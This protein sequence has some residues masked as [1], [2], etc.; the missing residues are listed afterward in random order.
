MTNIAARELFTPLEHHLLIRSLFENDLEAKLITDN[1]AHPRAGL[2]AYNNR[3]IFGGDPALESFNKSLYRYFH[4][5]VIPARNGAAFLTMFTPDSWLGTLQEIFKEHETFSAARLSFE[6]TPIRA[7]INFPEG[8]S[9]QEVTTELLA[10]NTNGLDELREEMGSERTSVEDFL[11]KSFG[12]C[13]V[14][15]NQIAAWCL[16]EYNT[17]GR[18]EIGIAT[19]EPHQRK[20]IA[21]A[22]T[23]AF[24]NEAA[25]RGYQ[26]VGW[27]CW[28]KNIA[29]AATARKAGFTL[30]HREQAMVVVPSQGE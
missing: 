27:D 24:L 16:S 21:T 5:I 14:Y 29:S 1:E 13:L 11:A 28:E 17:Q 19:Q 6:I 30:T 18:C 12:L 7:E 3:F 23:N 8:Y 26:H 2:I 22:L 10:S 4:E 9:L 15:E 20:G 25:Q